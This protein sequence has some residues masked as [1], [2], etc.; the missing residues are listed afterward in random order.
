MENAMHS[1]VQ[2]IWGWGGMEMYRKT[3][4]GL[5]LWLRVSG[6]GA[7]ICLPQTKTEAQ[8]PKKRPRDDYGSGFRLHWLSS[9]LGTG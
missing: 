7:R 5:G 2:G 1:Y 6:W 4:C 3:S 8:R 9:L